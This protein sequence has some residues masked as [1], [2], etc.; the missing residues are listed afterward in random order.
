MKSILINKEKRHNFEGEIINNSL[1][2]LIL[3][4]ISEYKDDFIIAKLVLDM[5]N[6][7]EY[8]AGSSFTVYNKY[9]IIMSYA[10]AFYFEEAIFNFYYT[11]KSYKNLLIK[12]YQRKLI[13]FYKK[14]IDNTKVYTNYQK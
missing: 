13:L 5:K 12:N 6:K 10:H 3:T 7:P 14:N 2:R 1:A 4:K 9:L 11:C 8:Y